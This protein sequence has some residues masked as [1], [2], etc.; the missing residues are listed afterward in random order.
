MFNASWVYELPFLR[1]QQGVLGNLFGGWGFAGMVSLASGSP[2]NVV[3]GRDF[4]LTGVGFDRPNL[5]GSPVR[6][7]SSR[8]EMIETFFNTEAFV[9]NEPGHYG[10]AGRN[11]FSGPAS[12]STDVSLT[13]KFSVSERLGQLQFR[14]EAFNLFN[15]VNFGQPEARLV[16]RNFGRILS[17]GGPRILQLALRW[18]F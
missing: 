17:A 4:S 9:P 2:V 18:N 1:A 11:P 16:N 14:A 10:N 3:S 13:K 5:V 12:A 15:Q 6:E 8:Q 7:H